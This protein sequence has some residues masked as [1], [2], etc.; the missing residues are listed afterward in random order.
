MI[1]RD[2]RPTDGLCCGI[3]FSQLSLAESLPVSVS[4]A[5]STGVSVSS[6]SARKPIPGPK[7]RNSFTVLDGGDSFNSVRQRA[8]ELERAL[9]F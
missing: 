7:S 6:A 9:R 3:D 8:M 5:N 4:S 2:Q 1:P